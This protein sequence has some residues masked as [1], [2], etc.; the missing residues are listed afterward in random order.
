MD[1][2]VPLLLVHARSEDA[3]DAAEAA[4]RAAFTLGPEEP[5]LPATIYQR[6]V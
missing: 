6:V 2:Q 1:G 4:V 5:E 3:A